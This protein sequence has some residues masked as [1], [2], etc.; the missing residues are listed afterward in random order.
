MYRPGWPAGSIP[1]KLG[2][3]FGKGANLGFDD[4]S[5]FPCVIS[6]TV[7]AIGLGKS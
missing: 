5:P 4:K 2:N 1:P 7:S 6:Y 3:E